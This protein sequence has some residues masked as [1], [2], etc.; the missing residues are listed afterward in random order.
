MKKLSKYETPNCETV[1]VEQVQAIATS[2][3]S[4][5]GVI[6]NPFDDEEELDW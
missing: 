1:L 5:S 2:P 4:T 6:S 3:T